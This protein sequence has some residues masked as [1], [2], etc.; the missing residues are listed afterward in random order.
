V[1]P[2]LVDFDVALP[3]A[4]ELREATAHLEQG[5]FERA[6]TAFQ[7]VKAALARMPA[8]ATTQRMIAVAS[9]RL[10]ESLQRLGMQRARETR[11]DA[12]AVLLLRA[13]D[14]E[15]TRLT[16]DDFA[17]AREG[18]S[19][20]A[21][22]LRSRLQINTKLFCVYRDLA[23]ANPKDQDYRTKRDTHAKLGNLLLA[24]LKE[25]FAAAT[26]PDGRRIV[27]VAS[28]ETTAALLR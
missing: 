9:Y 26:L 15:F 28:E 2:A 13:A 25:S 12:E 3:Q 20:N 17:T 16:G 10:G 24:R 5:R 21:A 4:Q 27:D 18:S 19:L 6:R 11:N 8:N 7:T 22:A 1:A 14:A 23:V